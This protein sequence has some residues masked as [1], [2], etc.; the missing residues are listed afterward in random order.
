VIDINDVDF[1]ENDA[2]YTRV[3]DTI[4]YDDYPPGINKIIL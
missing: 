4:F 1:V 2:H 3:V